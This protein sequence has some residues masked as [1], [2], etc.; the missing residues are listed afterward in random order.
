MSAA[1][2]DTYTLNPGRTRV[3]IVGA[4]F[5]SS[6]HLEALGSKSGPWNVI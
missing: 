6:F 3:A 2:P 5:I 4:G 1:T